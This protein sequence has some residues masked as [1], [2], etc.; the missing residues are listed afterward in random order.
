M[1]DLRLKKKPACREPRREHEGTMAEVWQEAG[2]TQKGT[3]DKSTD[4]V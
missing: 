3:L 1:S 2:D 4:R